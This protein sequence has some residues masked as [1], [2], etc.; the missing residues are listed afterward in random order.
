MQLPAT[1][2]ASA[3]GYAEYIVTHAAMYA[4]RALEIVSLRPTD[5]V[6]DVAAGPGSLVF[7]AAPRVARVVAIDFADAIVEQIRIR[8]KH[9]GVSNVEAMIMDAQSLDFPEGSFAAAFCMFGFMFFPDRARA[10]RELCRVLRPGGRAL[11]AT[12]APLERRPLMKVGF[13]S[14]AEALPGLPPMTKG[15]L[16]QCDECVQEM[17]GGG[18]RDVTAQMFTTSMHVDSA[19]HYL[20][21]MEGAGGPFLALKKKLGAEAWA[22]AEARL[23]D[24]VRRRIPE[25]GA[26]LAAEAILTVGTR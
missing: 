8:A 11:V 15:D 20:R 16:Q 25:P 2:N 14:L 4:K 5:S 19:E 13:E 21:V 23:L 3:A 9:D 18:F 12:W 17:S 10:F 26:D 7:V 6:L 22:Q 1:W 24:A